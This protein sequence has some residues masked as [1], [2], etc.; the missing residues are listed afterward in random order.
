[1]SSRS[2]A[3]VTMVVER[4]AMP[5]TRPINSP[6][7]TQSPGSKGLLSWS[8]SPLKM[9]LSVSCRAR[10][11]TAATTVVVVRIDSGCTPKSVYS[12]APTTM[13]HKENISRSLKIVEKCDRPRR[14][15]A[16]MAS[17]TSRMTP[18]RNRTTAAAATFR[19]AAASARGIPIETRS[20]VRPAASSTKV[21]V[22]ST[23]RRRLI[24]IAVSSAASRSS[25][26]TTTR[27]SSGIR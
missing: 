18:K 1:M 11:T 23:K 19:A 21:V 4:Q 24:A 12:T 6:A 2:L 8:I 22:L 9:L 17:R 14:V 25:P 16:S 20:S 15:S 5:L 27:S 13:P 10:P 26:C 3:R 7:F